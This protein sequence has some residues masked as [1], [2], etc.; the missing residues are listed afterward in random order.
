MKFLVLLFLIS[1]SYAQDTLSTKYIRKHWSHWSDQNENC[2]NTRH[3]ILKSRSLVPVKTGRKGCTVVIGKWNDYYFLEQHS[4]AKM[5]DID[6][7]VPLKHAHDSGG[8]GWTKEQKE[9]FAND[10]ENLVITNKIYNR[11][12]GPKTIAEWLPINRDYACKYIRDW[13]KIKNKYGLII[14][15]R[16]QDTIKLSGC[17]EV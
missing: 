17:P 12:K 2:L 15:Q 4:L 1:C 14:G 3:E 10:P 5:V 7:L 11:E 8:A 6:H 16:E 9:I 13:I